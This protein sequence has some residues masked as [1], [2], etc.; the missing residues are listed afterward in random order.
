MLRRSPLTTGRSEEFYKVV[1]RGERALLARGGVSI[2]GVSDTPAPYG[3]PDHV[4]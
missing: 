3:E 2:R 1:Q 4:A